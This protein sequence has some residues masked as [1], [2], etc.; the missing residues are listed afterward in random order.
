MLIRRGYCCACGDCC[1]PQFD[2]AREKAYLDAGI[3]LKKVNRDMVGCSTF[4]PVT[5]L[6]EDYENR[7]SSCRIFPLYPVEVKVLPRCTFT[8][9]VRK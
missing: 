5:R 8:F 3:E 6:C 1:D 2:E 4:N 9:E 7:P